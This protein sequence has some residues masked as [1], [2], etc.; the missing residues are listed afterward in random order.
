M[1][2]EN[3]KDTL[4][5]QIRDALES[6]VGLATRNISSVLLRSDGA[7]DLI[8]NASQLKSSI[9]SILSTIVNNASLYVSDAVTRGT[10]LKPV[11]IAILET[12]AEARDTAESTLSE[13]SVAAC[14]AD[15][16]AVVVV[17]IS[18]MG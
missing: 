5:H 16:D 7:N 8:A 9:H 10:I 3:T 14:I 15:L 11:R 6:F 1:K 12:I 2:R 18:L 4:D 13:E 17:V